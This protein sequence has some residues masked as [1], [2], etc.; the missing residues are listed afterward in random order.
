[1]SRPRVLVVRSGANPFVHLAP[2]PRV[3]IVEK[4]S[5]TI[6]PVAAGRRPR[7]A[8]ATS[9]SSRARSPS[10]GSFGDPALVGALSRSGRG[11]QAG[12]GRRRRRGRRSAPGVC[13]ADL[14]AEGLRARASSS[15]SRPAGRPAGPAALR[16]GC[17]RRSCPSA[18]A[19]A[20]PAPRASFSTGRSADPRDPG[21]SARFSSVRSRRSARRPP[22]RRAGSSRG[23]A[24]RPPRCCAR[25]R[26]SCWDASPGAFSSPTACAASR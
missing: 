24:R 8:P 14:V 13:R 20:A 15:S 19:R 21:S 18:C 26:R 16:G 17:R 1:M 3:E 5:H 7:A 25:L 22:P 6:E 2:S 9:P 4:V 10:R 11:R 23:S 12:R